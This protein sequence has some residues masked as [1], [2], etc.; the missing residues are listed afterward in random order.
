MCHL[1]CR[2]FTSKSCSIQDRDL[3]EELA[4][5]YVDALLE[6]LADETVTL[7]LASI[8]EYWYCCI[9]RALI[10]YLTSASKFTTTPARGPY[11][12]FFVIHAPSSDLMVARLK[13]ALFLQGSTAYDAIAMGKRIELHKDILLFERAILDGKVCAIPHLIK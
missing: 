9:Q 13:A 8:G 2:A 1:L 4:T 7:E 3:H 11:L 12:L 6:H 5:K 10:K